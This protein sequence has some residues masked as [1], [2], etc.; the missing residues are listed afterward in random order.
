MIHPSVIVWLEL[1]PV[2][3]ITDLEKIRG[4][5]SAETF[6]ACLSG[7]PIIFMFVPWDFRYV[8]R[9]RY[10]RLA[11]YPMRLRMA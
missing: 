1:F 11:D 10:V 9:L 8:F 7:H 4:G 5:S 2:R 3:R 6:Q